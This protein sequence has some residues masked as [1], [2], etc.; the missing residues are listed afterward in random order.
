V[1]LAP[2][3]K[4]NKK[5]TQVQS[6]MTRYTDRAL[7]AL[8]DAVQ[9][10]SDYSAKWIVDAKIKSNSRTGTLWH[11][12]VNKERGNTV[13]ARVETGELLR[14]VGSTPASEVDRGFYESQFGIRLPEAGGRKY[15]ME[16]DQGFDLEL[17]NGET[18]WVPG[19]ETFKSV[20]PVLRKNFR[21][22]MA[23]RGFVLGKMAAGGRS[24]PRES[25]GSFS[26]TSDIQ[27][28]SERAMQSR[29]YEQRLNADAGYQIKQDLFSGAMIEQFGSIDNYLYRFGRND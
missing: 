19:M 1:S 22:E 9:N 11:D 29:R 7:F 14:S 12:L 13:G 15:F 2:K 28:M 20:L 21:M 27:R 17:Y 5:P 10:V 8:G 18:K 4:W 23:S 24:A 26:D 3:I 16:Q 25:A 6:T